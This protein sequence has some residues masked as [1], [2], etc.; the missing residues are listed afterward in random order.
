MKKYYKYIKRYKGY[1]IFGPTFKIIESVCEVFLPYLTADIINVGAKTGDIGYIIS[2]GMYMIGLAALM[3]VSSITSGYLAIKGAAYLVKDLRH[4]VFSRIQEY[5]FKNIDDFSPGALITRITNDI[6]QIQTFAQ[7]S[8]RMA[9][10][11]PILLV[12]SVIMAVVM[13]RPLAATV[14][15]IVPILVLLTYML[16]RTASPRYTV[17]QEGLDKLNSVTKETLTNEKVIKSFAREDY[18]KTK[19]A[20][21]NTGL[22][23]KSINALK[24]MIW[25][26]PTSRLAINA[27]IIAVLW[28]GG[29]NIASGTIEI[30]TLTAFIG[31]LN[32]I[33]NALNS[34]ANVFLRFTRAAASDKRISQ[35]FAEVIDIDD[36]DALFPEKTVERGD[37]EFRNVTFRYY[38][39]NPEKVLDDVSFEV[40]SGQ[41]VGIIGSTGSGKTTLVSL[42]PRL[43]DADN[44]E[45]LIDG[46]NVKDY[47]LYNLREHV[48]MVLQVNTLFSGTIEENLRWGNEAATPEDM[49]EACRAACADEFIETFEN[50]YQSELEQGAE[51][52]SGGQKQ[53]LCIARALLKKPK[54]LVLDD[55]TSAVDTATEA[56]IRRGLKEYLPEA[57]K[58]IIA[59]RIT[60]VIDADIII[61]ME[62]GKIA[63]AGRHDDLIKTCQPYR[64]IYYSQKEGKEDQ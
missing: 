42:I 25:L 47:S 16:I 32:Q 14:A 3:L 28:I 39:S 27:A 6:T 2:N 55:S 46:I 58:L 31:Y 41:T 53:R 15:V 64:E 30:G 34:M 17:M 21:V 24:V 18:E 60:S 33:L 20:D 51:N 40:S 10:K 35:V 23:D 9:L 48:S 19:F 11:A 44:G 43:Y 57:T 61:V 49:R 59:Q 56:G 45:V 52:L 37:I 50:G 63:G 38:K 12:G 1:F 4:D 62:N 54:I 29:N 7:A 8:M 22:T 13:C 26:R 36:D 5:S